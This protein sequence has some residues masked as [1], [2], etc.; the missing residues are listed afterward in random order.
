MNLK[1]DS[2]NNELMG[3]YLPSFFF[4]DLNTNNPLD[5]LNTLS[6]KDKSTLFHEYVHF[7]Q[8]LTTTFGLT[9][10]IHTVEVQKAK[11]S[12]II[13][14]SIKN[15]FKVPLDFSHYKS[16]D[17][18]DN[19]H[20]M[21]YGDFE[22]DF[23]SNSFI[24][25]VT[26]NRNNIIPNHETKSYVE[27]EYITNGITSRFSFGAIQIMESMAFLIENS[28][29]GNV[30]CPVYPYHIVERLV[31]FL[32]PELSKTD[33]LLVALC[34]YSLMA[35]DPGRFFIE[36]M[37]KIKELDIIEINGAYDLLKKYTFTSS[38]NE[39]LTVFQL[40]E[41]RSELALKSMKDY[42]TIDYFQSIN[43]WLNTI[44]LD[45]NTFKLENFNFW[46]EFIALPNKDE[47]IDK[48]IQL[49]K[50]FGFPLIS[51]SNGNIAFSHHSEFPENLLALKAINEVS[52]VISGFSKECGM[53]K[54]CSCTEPD[55]TNEQCL[56][57]WKRGKEDH[58]CPFGQI[59]K[60][61]GIYEV[62]PE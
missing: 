47:R 55:I 24:T 53:Q 1:K 22:S 48:F 56:Q 23:N 15:R 34:D 39:Q 4:I 6:K 52:N 46:Y 41:S 32:Y 7:M 31:D 16:T 58:L 12:V 14:S 35:P 9:N 54:I 42:F 17:E 20:E 61:W 37:S 18:Y 40:F 3:E 13:N 21:F 8:D 28:L 25:R 49:T 27:V 59:I 29:F 51:N 33:A 36:F 44:F 5:D 62:S 60:M 11:N 45:F 38:E 57:P 43:N 19:L 30:S 50:Q 2:L 26:L 10:V